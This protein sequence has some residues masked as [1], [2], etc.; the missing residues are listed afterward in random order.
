MLYFVQAL[1]MLKYDTDINN[2]ITRGMADINSLVQ[3]MDTVSICRSSLRNR[4]YYEYFNS[5]NQCQSV[6]IITLTTRATR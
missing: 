5:Q 3:C 6:T 2:M 1:L 4:I